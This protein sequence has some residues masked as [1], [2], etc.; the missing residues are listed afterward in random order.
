MRAFLALSAISALSLSACLTVPEAPAP[1]VIAPPEMPAC[2]PVSTLVKQVIPAETQVRYAITQI[3]NPPY[4][5]IE[6][7]V[8]QTRVVKQA[9][10]IYV[11]SENREVQ[12][13]CEDVERG[14]IGP[15]PGEL[16]P[17]I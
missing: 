16:I 17:E 9:Q 4:E 6:S 15:A 14:L 10:I 3:D 1:V 5:P 11:N 2:I 12:N 13:I 8:K 7:R